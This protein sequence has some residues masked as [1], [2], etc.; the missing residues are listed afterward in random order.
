M[1]NVTS[2]KLRYIRRD[3]RHSRDYFGTSFG[4]IRF[5]RC[6]RLR[7]VGRFRRCDRRREIFPAG[8]E[9]VGVLDGF[10]ILRVLASHGLLVVHD[11]PAVRLR[12]FVHGVAGLRIPLRRGGRY[13]VR[14]LFASDQ[15]GF[16]VGFLG[17][18]KPIA[19]GF[20]R[21]DPFWADYL[22]I[23]GQ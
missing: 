20:D 9:L 10:A 4:G 13:D 3:W 17:S 11:I 1:E 8:R 2:A 7:H 23:L 22:G 16:T 6:V 14:E 18:G 19:N 15:P 21:R 12:S 5:R